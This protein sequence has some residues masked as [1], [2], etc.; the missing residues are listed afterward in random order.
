MEPPEYKLLRQQRVCTSSFFRQESR[1]E[2]SGCVTLGVRVRTGF[3]L[4]DPYF[5]HD[6][7]LRFLV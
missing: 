2:L 5:H 7:T 6:P 4:L 3:V 1:R